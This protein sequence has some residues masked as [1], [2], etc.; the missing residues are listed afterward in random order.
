MSHTAPE[1]SEI[2]KT[3]RLDDVTIVGFTQTDRRLWALAVPAFGS[4][5]AEP[6]YVLA[7]TAVVGH[8]GTSQLAGLSLASQAL[9]TIHAVTIFLAYGTTATVSRLIGADRPV[10]AARHGVQGLWL[11]AA[12]GIIGAAALWAT[13]DPVLR[14]LG[15]ENEVLEAARIYLR[16]SLFGLP[17]MLIMLAG[18]G[19]LRGLQDTVRPLVVA[20][21]TAVVNLVLE[22]VLIYG[23]D[24]DIGASAFATVV[25]QY[26]GGGAYVYW[27]A[28]A[29]AG[30]D[31]S[32]APDPSVLRDL[33]RVAG[34]LFVRTAALRGSFTVATA[35]AAR[36]GEV[37]L[38]SHEIAFQLWYF[39]ALA[40]DA[41]A[42]AGQS[43]IGLSLGSGNRREARAVADRS[44]L[45]GLLTGCAL[46]L[47][48]AAGAP[49]LPELFSSDPEVVALTT[50]LFVHLVPMQ[51]INGVVFALDGILIGAGDMRFLAIAMTASVALFIPL[52]V[53]VPVLGGGIGWVWGSLW[54][55]MLT[56]AAELV[57]RYRSDAWLRV[58]AAAA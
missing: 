45:W 23:F 21:A 57:W 16:I 49:V 15:G 24:L 17:A 48:L 44:V 7:D 32:L 50:F 20:V 52:V 13:T 22:L 26:L 11:G 8:L 33:L 6:L 9:L 12:I 40:L 34:D 36:L 5:I 53:A 25:A 30:H 39:S 41:V 35:S 28:R 3:G 31:V 58:G 4:L 43:M 55:L 38:A 29:V 42:I 51:P 27:V 47:L 46:A 18:V 37:P 56:R 1:G 10:E 2:S 54:V 14:L 19:Y